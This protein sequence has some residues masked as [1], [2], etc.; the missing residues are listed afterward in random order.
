MPTNSE[1]QDFASTEELPDPTNLAS[2][3]INLL[4]KSKDT[5][6]AASGNDYENT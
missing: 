6:N 3:E 4:L 1:G 5:I 2:Y